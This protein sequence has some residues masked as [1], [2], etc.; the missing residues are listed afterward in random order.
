MTRPLLVPPPTTVL[1][2]NT[3]QPRGRPRRER[4]LPWLPA[5]LLDPSRSC[6]GDRRSGKSASVKIRVGHCHRYTRQA[7]PQPL[8]LR[9]TKNKTNQ[10]K[11]K[12]LQYIATLRNNYFSSVFTVAIP[13][14]STN[15]N[16]KNIL[17]TNPI[18]TSPD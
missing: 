4:C 11:N 12:N 2:N 7:E 5:R 17:I 15:S 3:Q 9:V 1:Q 10:G 6:S 18:H 14:T 13:N 16:G 8:L